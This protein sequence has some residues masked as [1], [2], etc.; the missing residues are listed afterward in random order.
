MSTRTPAAGPGSDD[1][2]SRLQLAL[3]GAMKAKD[4]AAVSA[5]RSVLAAI[6]NAEAVP[7]PSG[8]FGPD[9]TFCDTVLQPTP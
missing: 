5:L 8:P 3:R 6:G 2:R 1:I 7:P 4:P 9:S